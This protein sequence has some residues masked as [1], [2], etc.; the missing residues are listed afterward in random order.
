MMGG[1][2]NGS[3]G[4]PAASSSTG[5][6]TPV[7]PATTGSVG[8]NATPGGS[9]AAAG[10]KTRKNTSF[11]ITNVLPSRPPSNDQ[12]DSG[13][14]DESGNDGRGRKNGIAEA[15]SSSN[16]HHPSTSLNRPQ[17]TKVPLT[18]QGISAVD[19]L[20]AI[21]L[22]RRLSQ[23][24]F[25]PSLFPPPNAAAASFLLCK[26]KSRENISTVAASSDCVHGP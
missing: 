12:E 1:E 4:T 26:K 24:F 6:V 9:A 19:G 22:A 18:G 3:N 23:D 7:L 14:E 21:A 16:V 13:E 8:V 15:S 17:G 11:K 25:S 20:P 2:N 5:L 10:T